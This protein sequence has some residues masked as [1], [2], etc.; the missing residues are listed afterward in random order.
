MRFLGNEMFNELGKKKWNREVMVIFHH[1][2]LHKLKSLIALS[3]ATQTLSF[4]E[5][6]AKASFPPLRLGKQRI[7]NRV[8]VKSDRR[9][10]RS[11]AKL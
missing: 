8:P 1:A 5:R 10:S 2:R 4:I 7:P 9:S 6:D 11:D 3:Q